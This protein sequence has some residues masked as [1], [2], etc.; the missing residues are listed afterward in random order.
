M[1]CVYVNFTLQTNIGLALVCM[2]NSTVIESTDGQNLWNNQKSR[3][4]QCLTIQEKGQNLGYKVSV[5]EFCFVFR[6]HPNRVKKIFGAF[7]F[8]YPC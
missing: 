4:D 5:Y 8:L 6:Y 3:D 2:V 1:M 7:T